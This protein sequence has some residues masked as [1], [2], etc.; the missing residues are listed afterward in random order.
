MDRLVTGVLFIII[1]VLRIT[2]PD[3][4]IQ[5]ANTSRVRLLFSSKEWRIQAQH[6]QRL[7]EDGVYREHHR[8]RVR[9]SGVI[10]IG[11]GLIMAA[12]GT[13]LMLR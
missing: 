10:F 3:P 6:A 11:L 1:G 13:V 2:R 8:Q 9:R 7:R 5:L 4:A 12:W